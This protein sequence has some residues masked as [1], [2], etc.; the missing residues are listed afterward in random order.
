MSLFCPRFYSSVR[1]MDSRRH[2]SLLR[3]RAFVQTMRKTRRQWNHCGKSGSSISTERYRWKTRRHREPWSR[4]AENCRK[5]FTAYNGFNNL[6]V[7]HLFERPLLSP[8]KNKKE[9]DNCR[10]DPAEHFFLAEARQIVRLIAQGRRDKYESELPA[11]KLVRVRQ[12][13]IKYQQTSILDVNQTIKCW[14]SS[15]LFNVI[16]NMRATL[17]FDV[18]LHRLYDSNCST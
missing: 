18:P 15:R 14:S 8:E 1:P 5:S 3:R 10:A 13:G 6:K 7:K 16:L 12:L 2:H 9:N 11:A 17:N 4:W